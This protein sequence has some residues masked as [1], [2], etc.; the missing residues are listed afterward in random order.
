MAMSGQRRWAPLLAVL[1]PGAVMAF[2]VNLGVWET[3][4]FAP[5][6]AALSPRLDLRPWIDVPIYGA[7]AAR[8]D[9]AHAA[10]RARIV[11]AVVR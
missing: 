9:P 3:L 2:S 1:A 8:L 5:A 7:A 11:L 10:D 6:L 4:G